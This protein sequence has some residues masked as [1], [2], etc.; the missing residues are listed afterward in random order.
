MLPDAYMV[1][2]KYS[3]LH[4]IAYTG[5]TGVP[6]RYSFR[7]NSIFDPDLTGTGH[8]PLGH[9]QWETF[10]NRYLV[11]GC[12][13]YI[14]FVN[15]STTDQMEVAVQLRPNSTF[16]TDMDTIREDPLTVFRA[17]L[18]TENQPKS[19][20]VAKGYAD[21]AKIR[22]IPRGRMKFESDYQAVFGNN[23]PISPL[24]HIYVQNQ[25]VNTSISGIVRVD[26]VY[27]VRMHDRKQLTE[28]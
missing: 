8:Q 21:V 6:G 7:V 26:L 13:Y 16:A 27:Y 9:D 14:N 3:S 5:A 17:V 24:I 20:A 4:A 23:P 28:S 10:Y 12:K 18:G 1:R 11:Y 22:G 2:L 15:Q 25:D 19:Q